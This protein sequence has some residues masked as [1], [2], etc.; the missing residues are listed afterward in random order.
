MATEVKPIP[1]GYTTVT[2]ILTLRDAAKGIE[3]YK[4]AFGAEELFRMPG[5]DGK[6]MH[7]ELKI[8]TSRIMLGEEAP[9]WD[10]R[11]P[12]GLGGT[13]VELYVY[14][15]DVDAA[16]KKAIAAGA[17][18]IMP[19]ADMFWGDR[20]GALVDPH[21]HRWSIATHKADLTPEQIE[22]GQKEWMATM[23]GAQKK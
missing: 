6:I 18:E 12:Q 17:K 2:P 16:F 20:V 21:G 10:R 22:K 11:G 14:V 5:P 4:R 13:P 3:F 9:E 15:G 1:D 23:Q 8:G 7:A 19:V